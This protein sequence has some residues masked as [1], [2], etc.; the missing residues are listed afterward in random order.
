MQVARVPDLALDV[1]PGLEMMLHAN[2]ATG[3]ALKGCP[4][5]DEFDDLV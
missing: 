1:V 2:V 3:T 4:R 5:N